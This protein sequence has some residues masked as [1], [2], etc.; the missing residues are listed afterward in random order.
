MIY[1]PKC[2]KPLN[3][4]DA[5]CSGC[6]TKVKDEAKY[7]TRCGAQV[8]QSDIVCPKCGKIFYEQQIVHPA[9]P[10]V[11]TAKANLSLTFTVLSLTCSLVSYIVFGF[12]SIAGLAFAVPALVLAIVMKVGRGRKI[13]GL[14]LSGIALALAI[15]TVILFF[16]I[17]L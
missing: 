9:R 12:L 17:F 10:A 2:G 6:G 11:Q 14:I 15:V 5:F 1:C 16:A 3:D 13:T 8:S 7:C 4:T